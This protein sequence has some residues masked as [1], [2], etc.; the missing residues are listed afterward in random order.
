VLDEKG[1]AQLAAFRSLR[2]KRED[3]AEAMPVDKEPG[4]VGGKKALNA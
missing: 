2:A 3:L 4:F 1:R